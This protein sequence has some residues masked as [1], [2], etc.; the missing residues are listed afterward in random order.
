M[1]RWPETINRNEVIMITD[2]IDQ[3]RRC[4]RYNG[5]IWIS[6]DVDAASAVAQRTG[7][8]IHTIYTPGVGRLHHNFG[9]ANNGQ[10]GMAKLSDQIGGESLFL[11]LQPPVSFEPYLDRIKTTLEK[12]S[13]S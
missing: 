1:K 7:T 12:M 13:M 10:N 9:E 8:V 4:L 5:L 6:P 2:G 3:A 11:G